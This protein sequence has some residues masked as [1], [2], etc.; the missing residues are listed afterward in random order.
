MEGI[1]KTMG[2]PLDS[3]PLRTDG[4]QNSGFA[5]GSDVIYG[6]HGKCTIVAIENRQISDQQIPFYRLKQKKNL[7][8]RSKKKE[9]EI[10]IP[11][12][13]ATSLGM[14]EPLSAQTMPQVLEILSSPEYYFEIGDEWGRMQ[15]RLED[16]LKKDGI[17]G[18]AKVVSYL[19]V[20]RNRLVVPPARLLQFNELVIK[21]LVREISEISQET[22]RA[23]EEKIEKLM[24]PKLRPDN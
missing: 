18:L 21:Q 22:L 9:P 8:S 12:D 23:T 17:V 24:K 19:F 2:Q 1:T 11:V 10:W 6:F 4:S 7:L 20:L 5:I 15:R 3:H 14:R 16:T 13:T